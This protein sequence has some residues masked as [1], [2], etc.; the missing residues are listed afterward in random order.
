MVIIYPLGQTLEEL[1]CGPIWKKDQGK[2]HLIYTQ[3]I[4]GRNL[5]LVAN[6]TTKVYT[7]SLHV[8]SILAPIFLTFTFLLGYPYMHYVQEPSYTTVIC[9]TMLSEYL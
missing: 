4:Y 9:V 5:C 7:I 1:Q 6:L 2:S 8:T 3:S